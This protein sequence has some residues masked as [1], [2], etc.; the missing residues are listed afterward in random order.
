MAQFAVK[1]KGLF[2]KAFFLEFVFI[3]QRFITFVNTLNGRFMNTVGNVVNYKTSFSATN[4]KAVVTQPL[5]ILRNFQLFTRH[6]A[7]NLRNVAL[8]LKR[9]IFQ[10]AHLVVICKQLNLIRNHFGII[11]RQNRFV[12]ILQK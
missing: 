12:I 1:E 2:S 6:A 11:P 5:Q 8:T 7:N 4:H 9:Q 10:N 3:G